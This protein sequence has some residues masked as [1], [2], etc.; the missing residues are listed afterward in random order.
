LYSTLSELQNQDIDCWI[1]TSLVFFF[2]IF[3]SWNKFIVK[4][5]YADLCKVHFLPYPL[6]LGLPQSFGPKGWPNGKFKLIC[7]NLIHSLHFTETQ[8]SNSLLFATESSTRV[9]SQLLVKQAQ[10]RF[11]PYTLFVSWTL[12][13]PLGITVVIY[14][15][16]TVFIFSSLNCL[17]IR[18]QDLP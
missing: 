15:C 12:R 11:N 4:R 13:F 7:P 2:M 3:K 8:S 16:S 9:W 5:N 10:A 6:F 17:R 18:A 1:W 14:P